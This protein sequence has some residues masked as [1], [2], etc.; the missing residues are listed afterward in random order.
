MKR[1]FIHGW[2]FSSKIW[3]DFNKEGSIF[4]DLPFH[5]DKR[6]YPIENIIDTFSD[7]LFSLLEEQREDVVLVGWSLGAFVS[8]K[9]ALKKPKNLK[10]LVLIGFS[11]KFKDKKL[12]HNP[13]AVKAFM[14]ALKLD[15][16][17]AVYNFRKT[18]VGDVF[19]DIPLP[20]KKGGIKILKEFVEGDISNQIENI[21]I[22]TVL[23]HGKGDKIVSPYGSIFANQRIKE[24]KLLLLDTHHAP[25]LTHPDILLR[26]IS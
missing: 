12:G 15:F 4:I 3:R 2:S 16:K 25:F 10:K 11:P 20:E 13:V 6:K 23:I 22:E 18:A 19:K 26:E 5:G 21:D 14:M 9:V 1:I 24:S 7:E 17:D 8:C